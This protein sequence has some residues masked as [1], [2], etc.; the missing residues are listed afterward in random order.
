MP[1]G[2]HKS[3]K[4]HRLFRI[5]IS[6]SLFAVFLTSCTKHPEQQAESKFNQASLGEVLF[7]DV[8]L[9]LNRQQSCATCHN[10]QHGFIDNRTDSNGMRLATSLGTDGSSLG[11]RNAPTASY[12]AFSPEFRIEKHPRFNSQQP[13]YEGY[14]GGQFLDGREKDLAGQAGGPPLNP[15]EMQMPDKQSVVERIKENPFYVEKFKEFYGDSIFE[16]NN[17]AYTAMTKAIAEFEKTE[18]FSPFDS[19]YDRV[20]RGEEQFSFK[21]LSGKSLFFSQQF[22]NCATCHQSKPN[23]HAQET[24]SN[25]EY[26]NIGVP[27]NM[28]LEAQLGREVKD[29]GL[30]NNPLVAGKEHLAKFKVPTLRNIAVTGPYMHNGVFQDLKTVIEFYDHFLIGSQHQINPETGEKWLEPEVPLTVALEEL[31]DGRKLKPMQVEQMVCFLRT[32]T[33][34]KYE[35]LIEEKGIKCSD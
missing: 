26:H 23:G 31:K 11:D 35:H 30:L 5:V 19:K 21:E 28:K 17:L 4:K 2:Q 20:L 18:K 3:R 22:T 34:K 24:F 8:N 12:A 27:A 33:D 29:K 10:P 32:L 13:D 9:S 7:H 25:Y 6:I 14:V 1:V 16:D 15:V